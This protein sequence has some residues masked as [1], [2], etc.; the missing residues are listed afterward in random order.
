MYCH[1]FARFLANLPS[2]KPYLYLTSVKELIQSFSAL[3]I[4]FNSLSFISSISADFWKGISQDM[5]LLLAF[6]PLLNFQIKTWGISAVTKLILCIQE[7]YKFWLPCVHYFQHTN[8]PPHNQ[9]IACWL[10]CTVLL[11]PVLTTAY[12][13]VNCFASQI[14]FPGSSL[15]S[16]EWDN[17]K[18]N[19]KGKYGVSICR[20]WEMWSKT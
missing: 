4:E 6:K 13:C 19:D 17:S 18:E 14:H 7:Y 20:I 10:P 5:N 3:L 8:L 15:A 16:W 2:E 9:P 11:G 1:I 12:F